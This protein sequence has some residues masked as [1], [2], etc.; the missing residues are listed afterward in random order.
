[1]DPSF[2]EY[3]R[4]ILLA[5]L[6]L[7]K[8]DNEQGHLDSAITCLEGLAQ[9]FIDDHDYSWSMKAEEALS[10]ELMQEVMER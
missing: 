9:H 3:E 4:A 6:R 2:K 7:L 5:T 10:P 8:E 1:Q